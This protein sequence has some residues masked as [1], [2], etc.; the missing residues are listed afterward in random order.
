MGQVIRFNGNKGVTLEGLLY[1]QFPNHMYQFFQEVRRRRIAVAT[2]PI[3][4][5]DLEMAYM[6]EEIDIFTNWASRGYNLDQW[7]TEADMRELYPLHRITLKFG[8]QWPVP[9][10]FLYLAAQL[11]T[12]RQTPDLRITTV[13]SE[14]NK[15]RSRI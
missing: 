7:V 2:V 11:A 3:P 14:G 13:D 6:N 15:H 8:L 1:D 4:G 12:L 5:R 10:R 9:S